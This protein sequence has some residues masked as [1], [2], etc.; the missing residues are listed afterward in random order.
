MK[1]TQFVLLLLACILSP[2]AFSLDLELS[3][4]LG[5]LAFDRST[6]SA[7]SDPAV[8]GAFDP[9]LFP[10]LLARFSGEYKDLAWNAGFERDSLLQNRLSANLRLNLDYFFLEA[11]PLI[12]L[13]NSANLPLNPG[14]SAEMGLTIP[15]I[16]FVRAGASSTLGTL[17]DIKGHYFQTS[18]DIAAGFWVPYVICSLNM[19]VRNFALREESNLLIEDGLTRYFFRADVYTKN[20]PYTIRV[21]LGFQSLRRSYISDKIDNNDLVKDSQT[22]EFK[23]VFAGL[24]ASYEFGPALKFILGAEMPV[25]SWGVRPMKDPPKSTMLFQARTGIIWTLP[26]AD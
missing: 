21:D 17:M 16:V 19:V 12:G 20:V 8:E 6:T 23:S 13:F 1:K 9:Q 15:G 25:Y 18:G 4:G 26:G 5:N 22:D 11:G 10:L 2:R 3:G 24:E 7:L 14:I